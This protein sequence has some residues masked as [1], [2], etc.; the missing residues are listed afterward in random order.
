MDPG[1]W[2]GQNCQTTYSGNKGHGPISGKVDKT[3]MTYCHEDSTQKKAGIV[4]TH[5]YCMGNMWKD[6]NEK[7]R[8]D[9]TRF[10]RIGTKYGPYGQTTYGGTTIGKDLD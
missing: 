8:I 9:L 6:K 2:Y 10:K 5:T 7:G 4:K 1:S 3:K